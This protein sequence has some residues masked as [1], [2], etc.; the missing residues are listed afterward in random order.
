MP[1]EGRVYLVLLYIWL[2]SSSIARIMATFM[3]PKWIHKAY[4]YTFGSHNVKQKF[5]RK[6]NQILA[7]AKRESLV[8]TFPLR[9]ED[10]KLPG[11]WFTSQSQ[12]WLTAT[13]RQ[14]SCVRT[15]SR[16]SRETPPES[17]TVSVP[18]GGLNICWK[19]QLIRS[20][21]E[22]STSSEFFGEIYVL[23]ILVLQG[24]YE[25]SLSFYWITFFFVF[26]SIKNNCSRTYYM[27]PILYSYYIKW[28]TTSWTYSTL[29]NFL[30]LF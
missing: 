17:G 20:V 6:S 13:H 3:C 10:N 14:K 9:R 7:M 24:F 26:Y 25:Q 21:Q 16:V 1:L 18:S 5:K 11:L 19:A 29:S 4:M 27:R 12:K 15:W 30:I 28:V 22:I 23:I 2:A 8:W